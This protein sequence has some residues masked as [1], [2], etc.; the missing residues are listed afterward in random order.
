MSLNFCNKI[1]HITRRQKKHEISFF[2]SKVAT[3]RW[4]VGLLEMGIGGFHFLHN[5]MKFNKDS[6]INWILCTT[7]TA[8]KMRRLPPRK[9]Q[10][11]LVTS[12][13]SAPVG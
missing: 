3:L 13:G 10:A 12:L 9:L 8:D 7:Q 1:I 4:D 11:L 5:T 2:Y 6:V